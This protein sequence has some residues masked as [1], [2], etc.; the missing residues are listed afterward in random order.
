MVSKRKILMGLVI[1]LLVFPT[2]ASANGG[3]QRVVDSKYLINLARSPFTP[4]I[5]KETSMLISFVD[6]K[7]NK[8][9]SEDITANIRIAPLGGTGSQK[10]QFLFE[11]EG[12]KVNGGI[13]E[14]AY[15]F[16]E[17]GLHETFIDFAFASAPEIMYESPD[18][19]IDVQ[20]GEI[21]QNLSRF[22]IGFMVSAIVGIFLGFIF[23][24]WLGARK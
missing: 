12:L 6:L 21:P 14:F 22:I 23:G 16:T 2:L 18:F 17:P 10:R 9:I 7:S 24:F 4:R 19:L 8:V 15:A 13:L 5:G 20:S 1:A 11:K 3:D